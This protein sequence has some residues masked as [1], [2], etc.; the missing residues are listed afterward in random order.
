MI[1]PAAV[2]PAY[3][4]GG[5]AQVLMEPVPTPA[6]AIMRRF[7]RQARVAV[8]PGCASRLQA[9]PLE[10]SGA[11]PAGEGQ[12]PGLTLEYLTTDSGGEHVVAREVRATSSLMWVQ[13]LAAEA[14]DASRLRATKVRL[15]ARLVP[16][17]TGRWEIAASGT[18]PITVVVDDGAPVLVEPFDPLNYAALVCS[19]PVCVAAAGLV[20]GTPARLVFEMEIEPSSAAILRVGCVPPE[21]PAA[22]ERAVAAAA[23]ADVAIVVVGTTEQDEGE[24]ADRTTTALP[25]R[26]AELVRRVVA[27]SPATVVVVNAGGAVDL[28]C[29]AGADAVL[30]SWFGGQRMSAAIAAVLSGDREPGGRLPFTIAR[31]EADYPVLVIAVE[32]EH[33]IDYAEGVFIGYRHFDQLGIEPEFCFGHG[34]GYTTFE[35]A[36]LTLSAAS[37]SSESGVIAQVRVRNTGERTGKAVVQLYVSPP[38]AGIAARPAS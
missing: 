35:L 3:M 21:D 29:A 18:G 36:D 9:V 15:I 31:S 23:E 16:P 14:A 22:L 10:R 7:G 27:A 8:E 33:R 11:L 38:D 20:A 28:S 26:Q 25:G 30:Y 37:I 6:E 17:R 2:D 34:L 1:G 19:P 4:G 32:D 13:G 5:S 12:Q 24:G